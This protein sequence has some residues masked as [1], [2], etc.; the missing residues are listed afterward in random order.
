MLGEPCLTSSGDG[1]A[2]DMKERLMKE[3]VVVGLMGD[4]S[5]VDLCAVYIWCNLI[6]LRRYLE[7]SS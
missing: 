1:G 4:T 7:S 5:I 2:L 3:S 6:H